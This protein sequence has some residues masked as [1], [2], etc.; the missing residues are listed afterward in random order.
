M[1]NNLP[2]SIHR[3]QLNIVQDAR[4]QLVAGTLTTARNWSYEKGYNDWVDILLEDYVCQSNSNKDFQLELTA[5][6]A[7]LEQHLFSEKLPELQVMINA[8]IEL[9]LKAMSTGFMSEVPSTAIK[10]AA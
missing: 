7:F 9:A 3:Q 10:H 4:A 5:F 8:D 6:V 2:N 1:N